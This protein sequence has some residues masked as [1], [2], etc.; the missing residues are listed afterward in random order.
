MYSRKAKKKPVSD[1]HV[2][3]KDTKGEIIE[4]DCWELGERHR[5]QMGQGRKPP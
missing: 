5:V 2:H 1:S 4:D 3:R